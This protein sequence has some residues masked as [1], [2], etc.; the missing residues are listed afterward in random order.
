MNTLHPSLMKS[1][2]RRSEIAEILASGMVRLKQAQTT[3]KPSKKASNS[4]DFR[5]FPSVHAMDENH[6]N[7]G[8]TDG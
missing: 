2:E 7:Q 8:E 3:K 5:V 1:D 6:K 4:L